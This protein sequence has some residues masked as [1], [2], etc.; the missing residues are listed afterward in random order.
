M[1]LQKLHVTFPSIFTTIYIENNNSA[2]AIMD[3]SIDVILIAQIRAGDKHAFGQLIER[4]QQRVYHIAISMI[5]REEVAREMSQEA[6]LQ[7]YLSLDSLRD[8][9]HFKSWL[10]GI[11][12]NVCRSYI[13]EQKME[14]LSL[15]AML[16][17]THRDVPLDAL[18]VMDPQSIVEE[19]EL[20]AI[21][22]QAVQRLS[23]NDRAVTL[24]FYYKQL[25]LEDIATILNISIGAVKGRLHRAR[26]QLRERLSSLYPDMQAP[27]SETQRKKS[28]VRAFISS[29]R[30]NNQSR[31]RVIFLQDEAGKHVL[32]VWVD[33]AV[34][35][36][37][38][39]GLVGIDSPRPMSLHLMMNLLKATNMQVEEVRIEALKDNI[40]YA[41]VKIRNRDQ[42][43]ELDARPSDALALSIYLDK[44][45]YIA[46]EVLDKA[47]FPLPEGNTLPRP[48]PHTLDQQKREE[49]LR[50]REE[51]KKAD[52][53]VRGVQV[54]RKK[55]LTLEERKEAGKRFFASLLEGK[56]TEQEKS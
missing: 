53:Q 2:K 34:A 36:I 31:Q 18:D 37:I 4:Y 16:G 29:I 9:A 21:V 33:K 6:I 46:E 27:I 54:E 3:D 26:K 39:D 8:D 50:K 14:A 24:M 35:Q 43:L 48:G 15:D 12:L 5:A 47:G 56:E 17:G 41:V 25:T 28:M 1:P 10:Y 13:R 44:P 23:A 11:T 42:M 55:N 45:I 30:I 51:A 52:Q 32:L 19:R 38:A 22:L 20:Y 7:A 49:I 40:Y